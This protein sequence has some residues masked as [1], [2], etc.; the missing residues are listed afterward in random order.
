[1]WPL[2]AQ[3][4]HLSKSTWIHSSRYSTLTYAPLRVTR[5]FLVDEKTVQRL[6]GAQRNYVLSLFNARFDEIYFKQRKMIGRTHFRIGLDFRWYIG[7]Y[8]LYLEFFTNLLSSFSQKNVQAAFQKAALLDMSIVLESYHDSDKAALEASKAQVMQQEKLVAVGLL[9]SG[10]AHEIG[11]PLASIQAI[12]DNQLRKNTDTVPIEMVHRIRSQV[13][14][15]SGIVRQLVDFSRPRP[16][17]WSRVDVNECVK[18]AASIAKKE[19]TINVPW[20]SGKA[21]NAFMKRLM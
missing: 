20:L 18:L 14:H 13:V 21:S 12:C 2:C 8:V 7:A 9:A 10:V 19:R 15:A 5:A 16:A 17:V 6:L 3:N 4:F 11:N 1:M